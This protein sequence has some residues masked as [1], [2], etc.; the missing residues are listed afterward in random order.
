MCDR[1]VC[2]ENL[3]GNALVVNLGRSTGI[4]CEVNGIGSP[5]EGS[6]RFFCTGRQK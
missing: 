3:Y 6:L 5:S 1:S 2:I 4:V